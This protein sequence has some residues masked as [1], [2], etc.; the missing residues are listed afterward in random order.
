MTTCR[1]HP[2]SRK[3][4]GQATVEMTIA[5]LAGLLFI[6]V[7][8]RVWVWMVNALVKREQAYQST[9]VFAGRHP[10]A[11]CPTYYRQGRLSVFGEFNDPS[12]P[13]SCP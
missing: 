4:R 11:G 10:H 5:M 12:T 13:L 2:M 3:R 8:F 9:R 1:N 6:V 7:T